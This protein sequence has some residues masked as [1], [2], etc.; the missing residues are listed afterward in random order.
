MS[1]GTR[2]SGTICFWTHP[3]RK[4]SRAYPSTAWKLSLPSSP[5]IKIKNLSR[6]YLE[7]RHGVINK[8]AL[9]KNLL[10]PVEQTMKI[11]LVCMRNSH[12]DEFT[13]KVV[14]WENYTEIK[15]N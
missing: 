15:E 9:E 4:K 7:V 5:S 14:G 1:A 6:T 3:Q 13:S 2:G 12:C 10:Y 11:L 8:L